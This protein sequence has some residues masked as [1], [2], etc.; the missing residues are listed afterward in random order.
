MD[1]SVL[2][3][4]H[5]QLK[6]IYTV[7]NECLD[8]TRQLADAVDRRDEVAIQLLVSMREEPVGKLRRANTA[9]D[10]QRDAIDPEAGRRL[11][12]LLKGAPPQ[13]PAEEPLAKQVS[14]NARLIQ[15]VYELDKIVNLKLNREKSIYHAK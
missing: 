14:M 1:A 9:L 15:Q 10:F 8:L 4:A 3:D 12:E 6:R 11:S 5:V 7:L 13:E 2:L